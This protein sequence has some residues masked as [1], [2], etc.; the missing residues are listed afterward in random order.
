MV[1]AT[2]RGRILETLT[3]LKKVELGWA[4][5]SSER[6]ERDVKYPIWVRLP[7]DSNGHPNMTFEALIDSGA[8]IWL[9][10]VELRVSD[11]RISAAKTHNYEW[12]ALGK[13]SEESITNVMPYDGDILHMSKPNRTVYSLRSKEPFVFD[14]ETW[15]WHY[16]PEKARLARSEHRSIQKSQT[17]RNPRASLKRRRSKAKNTD[18]NREE[19]QS[20]KH[21]ETTPMS[22]GVPCTEPNVPSNATGEEL[23]AKMEP[24]ATAAEDLE[25]NGVEIPARCCPICQQKWPRLSDTP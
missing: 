18:E 9:S 4:A 17:V 24:T 3:N 6:V 8:E 12:L 23:S 15:R 22:S 21:T 20:A 1:A 10:T 5:I 11:M 13:I 25:N 7:A 14:Y 19:E 2:I 16:D